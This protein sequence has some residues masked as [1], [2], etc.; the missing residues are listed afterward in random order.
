MSL[1]KA[2]R[3]IAEQD[4]QFI[5]KILYG[6]KKSMTSS[7]KNCILYAKGFDNFLGQHNA[8]KGGDF[9]GFAH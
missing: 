8:K 9:L 1:A 6:S 5:F 4:S 3:L 7:W 2:W